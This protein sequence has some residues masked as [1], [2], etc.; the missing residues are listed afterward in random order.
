MSLPAAVG[1]AVGLFVLSAAVVVAIGWWVAS[2]F[3]LVGGV[4]G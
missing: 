3:G 2:A 1:L 4:L